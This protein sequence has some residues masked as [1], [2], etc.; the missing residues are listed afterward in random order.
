MSSAGGS[1]SSSRLVEACVRSDRFH[2]WVQ[3]KLAGDEE[4]QVLDEDFCEALEYGLPPTVGW[5]MGI[6]RAVMV[7][8]DLPSIRDVIFFPQTANR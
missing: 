6:D 3:V 1:P 4:A 8:L 5:G 7:L 2:A